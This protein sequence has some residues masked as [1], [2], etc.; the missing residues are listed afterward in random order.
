MEPWGYRSFLDRHPYEMKRSEG[1]WSR[2]VLLD[3][4]AWICRLSFCLLGVVG[5]R[6]MFSVGDEKRVFCKK[7][8]GMSLDL[9]TMGLI[10]GV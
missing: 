1:Y 5:V 10:W 8:K 7:P 6:Y 2:C 3:E 4:V 9:L